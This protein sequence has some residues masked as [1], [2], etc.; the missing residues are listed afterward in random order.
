MGIGY[1][2]GVLGGAILAHAAYATIQYRAVLKITEEEFSRPPM[3]VMME[4]LLG[5]VL[6]MWAGLAVPTKFLSVL[7]HSDENR[8]VS[9]PANLDFMIFNHRGRALPSDSDLKLHT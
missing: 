2:V 6:C 1:V 4:L 7:P 9:L 8:I 3:D 5:L